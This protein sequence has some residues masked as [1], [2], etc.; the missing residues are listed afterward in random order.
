MKVKFNKTE[1]ISKLLVEIEALRIVFETLPILPH[2]EENL[3]R[4]AILKSSLFSARIEGNSLTLEQVR[5]TTHTPQKRDIAK[6]EIFNLLKAYRYVYM[7]KIPKKVS[8][9]LICQLHKMVTEGINP[10]AGQLRNGPGAIFNQAGVAIYLAP[11]HRQVPK[12]LK[13]LVNIANIPSY[14][15]AVNSATVHFRFEKIHPF[16]DGNGRVGRLLS[17]YILKN[18]GYGFKGL[19]SF[20]EF[21]D[22]NRDLY[23]RS[24]EQ[25]NDI[26]EFVEFFLESLASQAKLTLDKLK[27][28]DRELPED[29]LLPRRKEI[30][31]VIRDHPFCSFD[32][33]RRRFLPVNPKTLHYDLNQLQ[34]QGFV[35]KVG[36]SR[37]SVYKVKSEKIG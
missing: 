24:L 37:G 5:L 13:D 17:A 12:M 11:P 28:K 7:G 34:L 16:A 21:I 19:V 22:K 14:P 4:E 18:G 9:K 30:L 23:Y 6:R 3:R 31:N 15:L 32:L 25:E 33:I 27:E 36:V 26:T 1:N 20:E 2:I 29:N 10:E 35:Q 8:V